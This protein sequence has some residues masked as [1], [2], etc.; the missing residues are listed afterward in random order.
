MKA[1]EMEMKFTATLGVKFINDILQD[2]GDP[3]RYQIKD[4]LTIT[5]KQVLP[6]IPDDDYLH[7][8]EQAIIDTYKLK[9]FNILSCHFAGYN[10]LKEVDTDKIKLKEN[11]GDNP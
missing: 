1:Y 8:V 11:G 3:G 7:K 9:D 6:C 2:L 10:Y 4:A 5:I